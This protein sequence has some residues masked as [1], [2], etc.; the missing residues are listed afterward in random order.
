[1]NHFTIGYRVISGEIKMIHQH[2]S[3]EYIQLG[4]SETLKMDIN[5]THF[6]RNLLLGQPSV[7][8]IPI[9][10]GTQTLYINPSTILYV[11][12]QRRRTEIV[13]IDRAISCNSSISELAAILPEEFYPLHR[14][15]L[16]NTKYIVGIRRFEAEL[17]S[18]ICIPIP[19][20][21]YQKA[22]QDLKEMVQK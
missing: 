2:N 16:V 5:T 10:S 3:Y 17:L 13:C 22:K 12:S 1:M 11:Q 20:L 15:Y 9:R 8:R 14:S 18:G 7:H 4:E 6:V 21:T 19:A